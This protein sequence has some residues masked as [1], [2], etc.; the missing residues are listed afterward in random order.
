VATKLAKH[1][2]MPDQHHSGKSFEAWTRELGGRLGAA[3]PGDQEAAKLLAELLNTAWHWS[4]PPH[5]YKAQTARR[6]ETKFALQ[7]ATDLVEFGAHLM[8]T[9]PDPLEAKSEGA[10]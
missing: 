2:N 4:S 5:H 8:D 1:W 3:W 9:H 7:L 6:R 10:K